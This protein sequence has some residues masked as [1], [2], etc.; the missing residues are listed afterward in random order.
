MAKKTHRVSLANYIPPAKL[1]EEVSSLT[2]DKVNFKFTLGKFY[3]MPEG[4]SASERWIIVDD[5][6]T[7]MKTMAREYT[8]QPMTSFAAQYFDEDNINTYPLSMVFRKESIPE[9]FA[10]PAPASSSTLTKRAHGKGPQ[11]FDIG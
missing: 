11:G 3:R 8:R 10:E 9:V 1:L 5:D 2:L 7:G 6:V 4:H